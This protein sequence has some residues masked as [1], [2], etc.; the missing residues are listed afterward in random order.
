[1]TVNFVVPKE[2][3]FKLVQN[4]IFCVCGHFAIIMNLIFLQHVAGNEFCCRC[5]L[6]RA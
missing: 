2:T 6:V 4:L 3:Q 5:Q 1:M